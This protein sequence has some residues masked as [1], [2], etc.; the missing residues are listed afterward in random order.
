MKKLFAG[1]LIICLMFLGIAAAHDYKSTVEDNEY[2]RKY[3]RDSKK[4]DHEFRQKYSKD[5]K[6]VQRTH[7][8]CF[9]STIN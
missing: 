1:A 6:P 7:D 5:K 4:A 9:I 2:R 3:H 8:S